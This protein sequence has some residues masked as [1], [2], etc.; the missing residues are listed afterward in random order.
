[1]AYPIMN[2][3][4][5][6]YGSDLE[7]AQAHGIASA[8]LCVAVNAQVDPWLAEI[9]PDTEEVTA[10]D[11]ATLVQL[12]ELTRKFL[13]PEQTSF[14]FD[15]LLPV[16]EDLQEDVVALSLWCE[17]FLWG[18]GYTQSAGNWSGETQGIL[19]DMVEFTKLDP[20]IAQTDDEEEAFMQIHQYLRAAV[21]IIRDEFLESTPAQTH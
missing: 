12:F 6:R 11:R 4:L 16:D 10:E 19:R 13:Q 2:D 8:M 9:L 18:I 21:L 15:L 17:G 14:D 7:A 20:D 1:M 3:I 5:H